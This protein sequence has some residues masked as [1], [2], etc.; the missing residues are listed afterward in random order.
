MSVRYLLVDTSGD[1]TGTNDRSEL[2]DISD[3]DAICCI[4]DTADGSYSNDDEDDA[5]IGQFESEDATGEDF[6]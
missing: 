6:E 1:V 4:I 2:P 5:I 3:S